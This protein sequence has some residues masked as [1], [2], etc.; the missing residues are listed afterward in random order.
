MLMEKSWTVYLKP[1][2][3]CTSLM[4]ITLHVYF[5]K[6]PK[7]RRNLLCRLYSC[8]WTNITA[9]NIYDYTFKLTKGYDFEFGIPK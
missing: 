2:S 3:T 1:S 7:K 5:A 6:S 9:C 4:V 8:K